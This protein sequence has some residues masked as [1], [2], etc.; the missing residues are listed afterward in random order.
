MRRYWWKKFSQPPGMYKTMKINSDSTTHWLAQDFWT[1]NSS[2]SLCP[3]CQLF[4]TQLWNV[5]G[6]IHSWGAVPTIII[7]YKPPGQFLLPKDLPTHPPFGLQEVGGYS[8]H[9]AASQTPLD[10][11]RSDTSRTPFPSWCRR[12]SFRTSHL[13]ELP[14]SASDTWYITQHIT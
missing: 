1:I 6:I 7:N 11:T 14:T 8:L 13:C 12:Q 5:K 9:M 2:P 3:G 4:R 10:P